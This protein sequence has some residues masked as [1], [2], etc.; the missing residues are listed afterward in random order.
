MAG[1]STIH[2]LDPEYIL[3]HELSVIL[4]YLLGKSNIERSPWHS[5]PAFAKSIQSTR[6]SAKLEPNVER[7]STKNAQ[8]LS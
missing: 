3:G 5:T 1:D 2:V 8:P 7:P 6:S 4:Y